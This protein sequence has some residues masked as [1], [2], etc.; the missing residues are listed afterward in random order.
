ME[1]SKREFLIAHATEDD[2]ELQSEIVKL[3]TNL[4]EGDVERLYQYFLEVSCGRSDYYISKLTEY[5][6]NFSARITT[7]C[8]FI[9]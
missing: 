3:V 8:T 6:D 4:S 9:R 1:F 2:N 5:G 7:G